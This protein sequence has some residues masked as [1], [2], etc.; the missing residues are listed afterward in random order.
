VL[1]ADRHGDREAPDV[2]PLRAAGDRYTGVAVRAAELADKGYRRLARRAFDVVTPENELKWETVHPERDRFDFGPADEV[3]EVAPMRGHT[4]VWHLQNPG[5][6]EH[7]EFSRE[8][9]VAILR[10]HITTVMRRF[11]DVRE[12]DVVNE[13][14]SDEGPL[15]DSVWLRGIGPE[16]IDLAFRFAREADPDAKLFY[17][18]YGAEGEGTKA[19]AVL[20]LLRG[21]RARGVPV[22]GVGLQGHVDTKPIPRLD[23]TL[24]AY[25]A[26]GLDVVFTEVDVRMRDGAPD[27]RAQARQYARLGRACRELDRCRGFVVW[28]ISDAE[29]WVPQA[30]PGEGDALLFDDDLRPKPAYD[31][32]RRALAG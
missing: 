2:P 12:W 32:L 20:E 3:A 1:V 29:S 7:G 16:Y 15:R 9:L 28:G 24:A 27:L 13:A 18:D 30:Y 17:N 22:D 10:E 4:L 11:P 19:R 14:V 21:L 23:A 25:A 5:W 26:L 8:E 31:A 6:L